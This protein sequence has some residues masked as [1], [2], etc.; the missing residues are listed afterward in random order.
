[1]QGLEV[2]SIAN[3]IYQRENSVLRAELAVPSN[4]PSTCCSS[5]I[6]ALLLRMQGNDLCRRPRVGSRPCS[7]KRGRLL[8]MQPPSSRLALS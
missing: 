5:I 2:T 6:L 4:I 1:M 3:I 8:Q 7:Q